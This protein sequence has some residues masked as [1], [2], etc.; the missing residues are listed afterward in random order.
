MVAS[1]TLK[2]EVFSVMSFPDFKK[3]NKRLS[4]RD[5]YEINS[6]NLIRDQVFLPP[7]SFFFLTSVNHVCLC[8][9]ELGFTQN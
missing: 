7:V 3:K 5:S 2:V 8:K 6:G 9:Y 1:F 4:P